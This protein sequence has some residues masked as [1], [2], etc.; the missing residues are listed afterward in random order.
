MRIDEVFVQH[1]SPMTFNNLQLLY[2]RHIT[3]KRYIQPQCTNSAILFN[4]STLLYQTF[5][6]HRRETLCQAHSLRF[7]FESLS[8]FFDETRAIVFHQCTVFFTQIL[9]LLSTI[10]KR[11]VNSI[12]RTLSNIKKLY[13][14]DISK[15][16][17]LI[18]NLHDPDRL[19]WSILLFDKL[20][21]K[22]FKV[23]F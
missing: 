2:S 15:K 21:I 12:S 17:Y 22:N 13:S 4:G 9:R 3:A 20:L 19:H 10:F 6:L 23:Y 7:R 1:F 16:D 14:L 8:W 18:V 5:S 11:L